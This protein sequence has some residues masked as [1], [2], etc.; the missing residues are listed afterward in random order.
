M[1]SAKRIDLIDALR[2]FALFGIL[3]VNIAYFATAYAAD[4][5]I[6]NPL[7]NGWLDHA[8][9]YAIAAIFEF[10]IYVLFSFLFGYSFVLQM[11]AA[12]RQ[13]ANFKRRMLRRCLGLFVIGLLHAVF[14]WF[15][16]ILTTYAV[17]GAVLI[18]FHNVQPRT[19]VIL[20]I[21]CIAICVLFWIFIAAVLLLSSG[22]LETT[23]EL[24]A[25]AREATVAYRGGFSD[26]LEQRLADLPYYAFTIWFVQGPTALAMF[27]FGLAAAKSDVLRRPENYRRVF[28]RVLV[29]GL[30]VA[31]PA[32]IFYSI[33][34]FRPVDDALLYAGVLLAILLL[35]LYPAIYAS[36][37]TLFSFRPAGA[38]L[39]AILAPVGRMALSN[40]VLQSVLMGLIFYGYGLGQIGRLR[41][42]EVL[43]I[44]LTIFAVQIPV[45]TLWLRHFRYG[46]LEWVLRAFT[47]WQ[48]PRR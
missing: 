4:L 36:A 9:Q 35:P 41:P 11:E 34:V 27:F 25:Q 20:G 14:L 42:P 2:G 13:G 3:I 16:D 19:A 44:A 39:V 31:I 22:E 48:M 23:A 33:S 46:P 18:F 24:T 38:K 17:L 40:Y 26:V 28:R 8:V 45:S 1:P 29:W 6:P 30:P 43:L 37:I 32:A 5:G 10:K 21:T 15:G 47:N 7:V 12:E